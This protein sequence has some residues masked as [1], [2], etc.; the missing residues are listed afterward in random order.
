VVR[1]WDG[2]SGFMCTT[3]TRGCA[4]D[5]KPTEGPPDD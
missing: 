5:E 1:K 4:G 3:P 2:M